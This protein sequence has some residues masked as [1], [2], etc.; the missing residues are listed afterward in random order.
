MGEKTKTSILIDEDL[1]KRFKLKASEEKGLKG[2]S[3][4]VEEA[5]EEELSEQIVTEALEKMVSTR[6]TELDVK[7][8]KPRVETSAGKVI[9][10]LRDTA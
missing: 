10:E 1:W 8:V 4:A 2:V 5:L 6:L 3:K 7:P 9:R